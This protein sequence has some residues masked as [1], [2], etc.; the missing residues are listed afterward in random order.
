[1][2][3]IQFITEQF[4]IL[5]SIYYYE[6][7]LYSNNIQVGRIIQAVSFSPTFIV[8]FERK[9]AWPIISNTGFIQG[10]KIILHYKIEGGLPLTES[11]EVITEEINDLL[12]KTKKVTKL[13][14]NISSV[15]KKKGEP[16]KLN[17]YNMPATLVFEFYNSHFVTKTIAIK[18]STNWTLV[19]MMLFVVILVIAGA[20]IIVFG[21]FG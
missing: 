21:V 20:L 16:I 12:I 3:F 5:F 9:K 18:D 19:I 13:T 4:Y 6:V 14:A 2:G 7:F 1:M 10:R 8:D 15:D 17:E 11:T